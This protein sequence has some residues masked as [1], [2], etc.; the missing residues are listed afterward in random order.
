MKKIIVKQIL[1]LLIP[2]VTFSAIACSSN[3]R[4]FSNLDKDLTINIEQNNIQDIQKVSFWSGHGKYLWVFHKKINKS[5][6]TLTNITYGELPVNNMQLFPRK[7]DSKEFNTNDVVYLEIVYTYDDIVPSISS[8]VYCY[9]IND[10]KFVEMDKCKR[11]YPDG[12]PI[13]MGSYTYKY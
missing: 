6:H 2:I 11:V 4:V 13:E 7:G 12:Y 10:N 1:F 5:N 3:I 8:P 9:T